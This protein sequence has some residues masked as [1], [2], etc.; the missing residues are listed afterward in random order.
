MK[1]YLMLIALCLFASLA[2]AQEKMRKE[3]MFPKN[4][5][6]FIKGG[7]EISYAKID[8]VMQAWGGSF[9]ME[10]S[11]EGN[12]QH[13]YLVKVDTSK[14]K[15]LQEKM[16][17]A[18]A[19]MAKE[20][21][22]TAPPF[23]L[24]DINGK[25]YALQDLKGKVVVLN[26]WFAACVPCQHEMPELNKL[27]EKYKGKDVVFLAI[28]NDGAKEIKE[29]LKTNTFNYTLLSDGKKTAGD[30]KVA[31]YPTSIVIDKNGIIKYS[32][33]GG[34]NI[35]ESLSKEIDKQL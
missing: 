5:K 19:T 15:Q 29:F 35:A 6:Y 13:I 23:E 2:N 1:N 8:S 31:A 11:S 33:I 18:N 14:I 16:E 12:E 27:K 9:Q 30:Y 21:G 7:A 10:K 32:Q 22:K 28:G 17:Q 24:N 20:T 3:D 4:A 26:F 25:K 34:S